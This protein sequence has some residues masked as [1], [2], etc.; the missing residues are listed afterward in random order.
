MKKV[1]T[2]LMIVAF[3]T[4]ATSCEKDNV[5]DPAKIEVSATVNGFEIE[6]AN[7]IKRPETIQ[8]FTPGA[9]TTQTWLFDASPFT[10][11]KR[12]N[13][14]AYV[15][16]ITGLDSNTSYWLRIANFNQTYYCLGEYVT[17]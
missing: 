11:I 9:Y 3:M 15:I 6:I 5:I 12:G 8:V 17:N 10:R 7:A 4:F 14:I 16:T 1:L 2:S 13:G